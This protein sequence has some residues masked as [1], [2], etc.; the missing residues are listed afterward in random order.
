[1]HLV[2]IGDPVVDVVAVG[3]ELPTGLPH[4]FALLA[5]E[6]LTASEVGRFDIGA[7]EPITL[8]L[9]VRA[10]HEILILPLKHPNSHRFRYFFVIGRQQRHFQRLER[11]CVVA[12]LLCTRNIQ[13]R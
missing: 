5:L 7:G 9:F 8:A 1:M 4:H 11:T 12:A 2:E 13:W 3:V 10:G 6:R